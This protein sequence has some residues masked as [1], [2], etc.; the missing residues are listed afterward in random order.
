VY[1]IGILKF[2]Y[3]EVKKRALNLGLD[4]QGGMSVV[5]EVSKYD[6]LKQ[7][8]SDPK[9]E[10][11]VAALEKAHAEDSKGN[12]D[13][14]DIFANDYLEANPGAQL[15]SLFANS[16]N[17]DDLPRNS[18]NSDVIAWLKK[19]ADE[20]VESTYTKLKERIDRFGVSS[21]I[22][23]LQKSTGRIMV[24]L[25]GVDNPKRARE[26]L[27]STANL[28]FWE[29]WTLNDPEISGGINQANNIL[30]ALEEN[31]D[32]TAIN[33]FSVDT[34]YTAET[35]I[36]TPAI[37]TANPLAGLEDTMAEADTAS[38]EDENAGPIANTLMQSSDPAAIGTVAEADTLELMRYFRMDEVQAQFPSNIKFMLGAKPIEGTKNYDLY[39]IKS[40]QDTDEPPLDGSAIKSA[41][42]DRD[43]M[44]GRVQIAMNMKPDGARDWAIITKA[45]I[46]K[47]IAI[48][49][50]NK[51]YSAPRVNDEITGGRS[52]I[53]GNFTQE[54]AI[55]LSNILEVGKLPVPSKIVQEDIVGPS[56]GAESI[57]DGVISMVVGL[58]LVIIFMAFYYA[59]A[60]VIADL[61]LF[62]NIFFIFGVLASIG[63]TLTLPGIA[64]LVLT[65]GMAV[66]A[67]VIIY[68]RVREELAKGKSMVKAIA[69]GYSNSYSAIID[70]HV[71]TFI[72]GI[73]LNEF[74]SGPIKGFAIVL[75]IGIVFSLFT[76]IFISR[77]ILD[78]MAKTNKKIT[79]FTSLTQG[80]F[81][82]I[83]IKFMQ[84]RRY[85]YMFSGIITVISI[86][87]IMVSGFNY[88]VEFKGGRSYT[89]KFEKA[90]DAETVRNQLSEKFDPAVQVK[91]FSSAEKLKITTTYMIG[92]SDPASDSIATHAL[93]DNIK[94]FYSDGVDYKFWDANY[95]ESQMKVEPTMAEDIKTHAVWAIGIALLCT[96]LYILIRFRRWQFGAGAVISLIHD[97]FMTLAM[98]ALLKN[99]MPFTLQIDETFIAAILTI[100]GYSIMDTVVVY[101]RIREYLRESKSGT[102]V[103]VFN[104]AINQTL[105]RT[106]ITSGVTILSVLAILFFG[107]DNIQGFAFAMVIGIA[108]GTYSSV[109][110]ASAIAV[111]LYKKEHHHKSAEDVM[112]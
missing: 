66:D 88:G 67:N 18:S 12:G 65:M 59:R 48:T 83:N 45:N 51:V 94:S 77:L 58:L 28:E 11:F 55:D 95:K 25:P 100:I 73:I 4:L 69:D 46:G 17:V 43:Q 16:S 91:T 101:D 37:D 15:V 49:L 26:L 98:F 33:T 50:D 56:L 107:T 54:E 76:A 72:I 19:S 1:N 82:H 93:F 109:F 38:I 47:F 2:N 81:K 34:N 40:Q 68:E 30:I 29:V 90:I 71:T 42:P 9:N 5:L 10:K 104:L 70:S 78:W 8:C 80:A 23:T 84:N 36:D 110:I 27:Q 24:E 60:G 103:E 64:G 74:G 102:L 57:R 85:G 96:F 79:Y 20:G 106:V 44:S 32:T 62:A 52:Q 75:M 97:A 99:V 31:E 53:S 39:A 3:D 87:V 35:K 13:I 41:S 22:V 6:L 63:A 111:D 112:K 7:L 108:F 14:I 89:V 61:A 105:S 92:S 86:I 21:P